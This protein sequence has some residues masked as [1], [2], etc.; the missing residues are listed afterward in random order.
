MENNNNMESLYN[1]LI[2]TL[3]AM[4]SETVFKDALIIDKINTLENRINQQ[5]GINI[6]L[7]QKFEDIAKIF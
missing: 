4:K 3:Q 5:D 6:Q 1:T 2:N 7:K